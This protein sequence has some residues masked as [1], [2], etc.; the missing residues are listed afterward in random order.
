MAK[1]DLE[2]EVGSARPEEWLEIWKLYKQT[3]LDTYIEEKA[4]LTKKKLA[5]FLESDSSYLPRNWPKSLE[6]PRKERTVYVARHK[7]EVVGMVVPIFVDDKHRI[8]ALYVTPELQGMGIG[9]HLMRKALSHHGSVDVY[10]GIA[11]HIIGQVQPFYESFGFR[12]IQPSTLKT[13]PSDPMAYIE[14]LRPPASR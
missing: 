11:S 7:G 14:M 9:T 1:Q 13:Y 3:Y 8:T 4:G 10:I 12:L 6:F 2:I 5:D